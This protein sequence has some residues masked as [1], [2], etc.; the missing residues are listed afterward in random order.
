MNKNERIPYYAEEHFHTCRLVERC[1][2]IRS[3]YPPIYRRRHF[4][5]HEGP[6]PRLKEMGV[7]IL[8]FMPINPIGEKERKGTLGSNYAVRDYTAVNP[9]LGTLED[10]K[11]L[12]QEIHAMGMKVLIDWVANHTAWDHAWVSE[13]PEWYLKDKNGELKH[14]IYINEENEEEPW[15]DVLGLDYNQKDL[16]EAMTEALLF[17]IRETDIDG[18]RCDVAGLLPKT[19]WEQARDRMEAVKPVFMLAEW[20]TVPL[21]T[22]AFDMTYDWGTYDCFERLARG[23]GSLKDLKKHIKKD[24]DTF[25]EDAYRMVFTTNHDKNTWVA[26]DEELYGDRFQ[27]WAVLSY[28]LP[29]MPLIYSGQESGLDKQIEFF[30]KDPIDWKD[31][32]F[33]ALYRDLNQLKKDNPALWNGQYGG[34]FEFLKTGNRHVLAIK[35]RKDDNVVIGLFNL[36][37]KKAKVK[38]SRYYDMMKLEPWGFVLLMDK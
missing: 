12:V 25:P 29:G 23:K 33:E 20:S 17:W 15:E 9:E 3:Q 28:L 13:H 24:R 38:G 21:H 8:W 26:S 1:K 27:I 16:W 37:G 5:C 34:S 2:Y 10:F 31:F 7:D 6:S 18:F 22:K 11:A 32:K 19:F 35:R 14:Y 30:E 4:Q 36:A